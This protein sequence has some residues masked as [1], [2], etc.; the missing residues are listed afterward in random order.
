MK[1]QKFGIVSIVLLGINAIMGSGIFLLPG[2]V[3]ASVGTSSLFVYLFIMVLT[4][5]MALCFAEVG[6]MFQRNG[7]AY[8]YIREAFG[9]FAGFE[10][11]LMKWIVQII[12]WATMAAGFATALS[13]LIPAAGSGIGKGVVV[14][15]LLVGLGIINIIG[16]NLTKYFNNIAT[17]GKILPLALFILVGVFF[18]HPANFHP[19]VPAGLTA[20]TFSGAAILIFY[21]FAGFESIAT[22]AEDMD[23]PKR[24]VPLAIISAMVVVSIV[25]FM[26]QTVS[27]GTLGTKL[28]ESNTPVADAMSTFWG[29]VGKTIVI[30]GTLVS[31]GGISVAASFLTPRGAL[32]LAEDHILP[33]AVTRRTSW[34]T[35]YIA[36]ILSVVVA[37]PV[38]LSGTFI[39]LAAISVISRFTQ[40]IPTCLAIIVF[41]RK[42]PDLKTTFRVPFGYTIPILA[43]VVS[44]WLLLNADVLKLVIGLGALLAGVPLYWLN[45]R[46]KNLQSW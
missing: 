28:A 29:P 30:L 21:A 16:V 20:T 3:Y 15:V 37:L 23:N 38:A 46:L 10:V 24:S 34:G 40:Y 45:K 18:I 35:P 17:V 8:V 19:V 26:I 5:A 13:S 36:I 27:I 44:V 14:T 9:E 33:S 4:L 41:R 31:I 22:A 12:A 1:K 32:A 25:Y 43:I 7:G 2:Q 11:G 42:R 39:Q 6:G